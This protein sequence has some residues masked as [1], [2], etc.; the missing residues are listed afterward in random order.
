[1]QAAGTPQSFSIRSMMSVTLSLNEAVFLRPS[2]MSAFSIPYSSLR[3]AGMLLF[4]LGML[5][6]LFCILMHFF[7]LVE[8]F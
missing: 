2:L 6:S 4:G 8:F 3:K 7:A 1:M 5:P